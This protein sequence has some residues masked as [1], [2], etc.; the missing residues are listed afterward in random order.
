MR[1]VIKTV[2]VLTS[3]FCLIVLLTLQLSAGYTTRAEAVDEEGNFLVEDGASVSV[4]QEDVN[5]IKWTIKVTEQYHNYVSSLG[6]VEYHTLIDDKEINAI[7]KTSS[8]V[9]IL[10]K[11]KPNFVNGVFKYNATIIY[12]NL[13][14]QLKEK[15][16]TD[17]E[18]REKIDLANKTELNAKAYVKI[19]T[20]NSEEIIKYSSVND[21]KRSMFGVA[22]CGLL[23]GDYESEIT[24]KLKKYVGENFEQVRQEQQAKI[25]IASYYSLEDKKGNVAPSE[26][27]PDGNYTVLMGARI[28]G[29]KQITS[30]S[31]SVSLN[32]VAI[33]ANLFGEDVS[34]DF[35]GEDGKVYRVPVRIVT[36][37]ITAKED[38]SYFK[39]VNTN[40]SFSGY[41]LLLNDI[42]GK[43]VANVA[44]PTATA[45]GNKKAG[46]TGVF[47]GNGYT[48]K[49]FAFQGGLFGMVNGGTVRNL[50]MQ[51]WTCNYPDYWG[52]YPVA[53]K[54]ISAKMDNC[55][56]STN[57]ISLEISSNGRQRFGGFASYIDADTVISNSVIEI[58]YYVDTVNLEDRTYGL[59]CGGHDK[60][61]ATNALFVEWKMNNVIVNVNC[62]ASKL[63]KGTDITIYA[64]NQ[65]EEYDTDDVSQNKK[66]VKGVYLN[67]N[68]ATVNSIKDG[69]DADIWDIGDGSI[70]WKGAA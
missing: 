49:N 16:Y 46:L 42:D 53:Q 37:A 25:G 70:L 18:I 9:D 21:S 20:K 7:D 1:N 36:K 65:R 60:D 62:G 44:Q 29:K 50:S 14:A 51:N 8:Q 30:T 24:D 6:T 57:K 59:I 2:C 45:M 33:S 67:P 32:N 28:V 47:E 66:I 15:G 31:Q 35:V 63:V 26:T 11:E 12:K 22:V 64:E 56:I 54:F 10:C 4:G 69:Y 5:G 55:Y 19:I 3:F 13:S 52:A 43:G 68:S 23:N 38:V 58:N 27:I 48:L 39:L 17:D 41:Y 34:A 40:T 61:Y